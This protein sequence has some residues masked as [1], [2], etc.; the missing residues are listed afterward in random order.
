[1]TAPELT[2][3]LTV[4]NL[5]LTLCALALGAAWRLRSRADRDAD[6]RRVDAVAERVARLEAREPASGAGLDLAPRPPRRGDPARPEP[7]AGPTL[8]AV[9]NLAAPAGEPTAPVSP[10]LV[11]RFGAIWE[12]ADAGDSAG[13]IARATGQPIGQVEL[14]LGLKR[15]LGGSG[16][17]RS[18]LP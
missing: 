10:D 6:A 4:L 11:Q 12:M 14:I 9:P 3:T 18:R 17:E 5:A 2:T 13:S 8:I 16:V 15:Q 1:M 7:A